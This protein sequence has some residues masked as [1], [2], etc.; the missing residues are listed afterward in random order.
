RLYKKATGEYVEG[1]PRPDFKEGE[2]PLPKIGRNE[3][4]YK[5]YDNKW[6]EVDGRPFKIPGHEGVDA[7]VHNSGKSYEVFE[8][9]SGLRIGDGDT[10][11]E[12]VEGAKSYFDQRG[13]AAVEERIAEVVKQKGMSPKYQTEEAKAEVAQPAGNQLV[14]KMLEIKPAA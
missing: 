13:K 3:T 14:R 4:F 5:F 11:R 8:S 10:L 1:A 12:A 2:T 9:R 6:Q 7:F